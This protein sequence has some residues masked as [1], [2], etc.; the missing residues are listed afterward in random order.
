MAADCCSCWEQ[1]CRTAPKDEQPQMQKCSL[2][3]QLHGKTHRHSPQPQGQQVAEQERGD[4][5]QQ[6][7]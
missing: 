7:L 3:P 6:Q 1:W 4:E 5:E 2:F